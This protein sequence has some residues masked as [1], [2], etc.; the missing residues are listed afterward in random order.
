M[1]MCHVQSHRA[2]WAWGSMNDLMSG[3]SSTESVD[4]FIFELGGF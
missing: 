3:R 4:S 2:P 1:G